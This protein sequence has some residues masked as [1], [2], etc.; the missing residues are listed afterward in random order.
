MVR[1]RDTRVKRTLRL[2]RVLEVKVRV[3]ELVD[4]VY[5][6]TWGL[7]YLICSQ[8]GPMMTNSALQGLKHGKLSD[9]H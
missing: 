8:E 9:F 6:K 1:E 7:T 3:T 2:W 5:C 4:E